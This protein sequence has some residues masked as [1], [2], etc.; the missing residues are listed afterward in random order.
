M[1]GILWL[2]SYPKSGNTWLRVFLANYFRNPET[3]FDINNLLHFGFNE[4]SR[5]FFERVSPRPVSELDDLEIY[6]L[7]PEVHRWIADKAPDTAFVKTHCALT[8]IDG[9]PTVT[10]EVTEGA[11][12][13]IRNPLDVAASFCS[14]F[15]APATEVVAAMES[16]TNDLPTSD[17]QVHQYLGTWAEHVAGWADA[18]GMK[19]LLVR[20]EDMVRQPFKTFGRVVEF[21][22]LPEDKARLQKAIRFSGFKVLAA[23]EREHGFKERPNSTARFFHKGR[24]GD[25]RGVLSEAQE[26]RIVASQAA[27]MQRF[28]Y[29]GADGRLKC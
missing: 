28:G 23:Q 10:L 26:R 16:S 13:I 27:V 17:Q 21:L 6:H 29:L 7:R 15:N 24:V 22:G 18:P 2:A 14:F 19:R 9:F 3:P 20:Y 25:W 4:A 11:I 8:Q 12:Y 5:E 1:G